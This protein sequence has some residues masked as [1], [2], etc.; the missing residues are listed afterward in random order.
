VLYFH[1][2]WTS[3]HEVLSRPSP[4]S[5]KNRSREQVRGWFEKLLGFSSGPKPS[6]PS[7]K[8]SLGVCRGWE[9]KWLKLDLDIVNSGILIAKKC[10]HFADDPEARSQKPEAQS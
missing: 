3:Q 2:R 4:C 1:H 6:K 7:S 9:R 8:K 10:L 5:F